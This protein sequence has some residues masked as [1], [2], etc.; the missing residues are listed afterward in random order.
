MKRYALILLAVAAVGGVAVLFAARADK[1]AP[2]GATA[3]TAAPKFEIDDSAKK[4][5]WTGLTP[6][7]SS[8][9]FQFAVVAD[10][11]GGHRRGVFSKAVQQINLMHP[12]FVMSVGDLIEGAATAEANNKQWDEFDG[13]AKQFKM[14]FF[15]CPGNHD[16]ASIA[17]Q[18]VWAE[19]LGKKYYHF[20]YKNSLFV[21]L[22]DMDYE[23]DDPKDPPKQ[24]G[25]RV[26][27]RQREYL[28]AALKQ[29]PNA[30]HT[31][32]F[33]HHPIWNEKD[34][35]KN[36]WAAV[37]GL[38]KGRKH[39]VFCGHVHTYR[40]YLRN[41][42]AYYQLAT[43]GGSSAMR[44]IEYGEFDQIGWVTMTKDG[45][46]LANVSLDGIFKDDLK[47]FVTEETGNDISR[48]AFPSVS[49]RVTVDGKPAAGWVVVLNNLDDEEAVTMVSSRVKADGTF[50]IYGRRGVPV[51]AGKYFVTF[52]PAPS[53]T[54]DPSV[55][56][57]AVPNPVPEKYRKLRTTPLG[58]TVKDGGPNQFD[59]DVK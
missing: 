14:P 18:D 28:E 50:A 57:A 1:A 5:P 47:P 37:E 21:V 27:K 12:E 55:D 53:L 16:A 46:T 31:F 8:E 22:N 29:Y 26:G 3:G 4:N 36:G 54:V 39:W 30:A 42:T 32:L 52:E 17:K 20:A 7:W 13:Y 59:F 45:P 34:L 19:R 41:G 35:E 48:D 9:Q 11:T 24:Q 25:L 56:P 49:G 44:G 10:R 33:L 15:Y 51:K 43:T 23:A 6:N 2:E 40:K 58:V 38:M